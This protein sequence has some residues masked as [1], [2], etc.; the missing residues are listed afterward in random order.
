[1]KTTIQ[2]RIFPA[3]FESDKGRKP[4]FCRDSLIGGRWA[5][6]WWRCAGLV[7]RD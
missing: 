2:K 6:W 1:M 5:M 3:Q 4:R 7:A